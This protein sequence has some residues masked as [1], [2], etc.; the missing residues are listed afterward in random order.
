MA[1]LARFHKYRLW[2][3][4]RLQ[5]RYVSDEQFIDTGTNN[6]NARNY[7]TSSVAVQDLKRQ[8][9][10]RWSSELL[11]LK[12]AFGEFYH[13]TL[14]FI[15]YYHLTPWT[16][17][18]RK[19]IPVRYDRFWYPFIDDPS[20]TAISTTS[21]VNN[22]PED[23]F[24]APSAVL[25]TAIVPVNSTSFSF[26]W[27]PEGGATW[28]EY[29][30]VFYF[31][32]IQVLDG[33][34]KREFDIYRNDFRAYGHLSPTYLYSDAVCTVHPDSGSSRYTYSFNATANSTLP[35]L[36]NTFEIY[37]RMLLP[38]MM[39]DLGD[40]DAITAIKVQYQMKRNWMGDPCAP[41]KYAWD[42]VICS[43]EIFPPAD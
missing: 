35:P 24:E 27:E 36:I 15:S 34:D 38:E 16:G 13:D 14:C 41:K 3:F 12:A 19:Q 33:G 23:S 26:Y 32:E 6:D 37:S 5:L 31:A 43:Y 8:K 28:T 22:Y 25:Q 40:V 21:T 10:S 30:A 11:H 4:E 42:G 2:D 1:V 18:K 20:W 39:T 9:L 17:T 7:V 29:Y